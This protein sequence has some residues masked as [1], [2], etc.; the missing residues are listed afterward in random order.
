[1]KINGWLAITSISGPHDNAQSMA[2]SN[3]AK[4]NQYF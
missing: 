2:T 4:K 3:A 1:M